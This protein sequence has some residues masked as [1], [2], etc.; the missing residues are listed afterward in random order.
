MLNV[1]WQ[2]AKLVHPSI[3]CFAHFTST[4]TLKW[5]KSKENWIKNIK[6]HYYCY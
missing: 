4:M 1:A 2:T 6:L 3:V 5:C